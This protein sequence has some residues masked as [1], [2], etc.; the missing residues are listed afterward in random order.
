MY[1]ISWHL[2]EPSTTTLPTHGSPS[3]VILVLI[4]DSSPCYNYMVWLDLSS[5]PQDETHMWYY[6]YIQEPL[7]GELTYLRDET[8]AVMLLHGQVSKF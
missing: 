2:P 6:E 5:N 4:I 7:A 8:T 1:S 3:A